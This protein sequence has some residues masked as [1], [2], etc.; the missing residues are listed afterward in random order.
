MENDYNEQHE[1]EIASDDVAEVLEDGK[2]SRVKNK[3][4]AWVKEIFDWLEAVI[5]ALVAIFIIFTFCFRIVGVDGESMT[6]TLQNRDWLMISHVNFDPEYKDI[7][8]IT[9]PNALN[10]PLIKRVIATGGD[11][12]DIDFEQGIVYVNDKALDE[13][14]TAAP[15]YRTGDMTFPLTVP[16]GY[17]FVMG[18][19]RNDS[20]D[21]RFSMIG[22]IDERYIMGKVVMRLYP[23]ESISE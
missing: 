20:L 4:A 3:P 14:Y 5:Y 15:T 1:N 22:L 21:S 6:P 7:V 9:Q 8:V 18:D 13:P 11:T 2:E 19:N 23:F 12:I 17:V 10:E 16:E